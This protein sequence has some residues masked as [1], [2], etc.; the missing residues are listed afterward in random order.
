MILDVARHKFYEG[1]LTLAI[2]TLVMI[3]VMVFSLDNSEIAPA[4][5][6]MS[7]V[8]TTIKGGYFIERAAAIVMYV[9]SVLTLARSAIRTHIY[10]TNTMAPLAL[11][12]M[13]MFP[14]ICTGNTLHQSTITLLTAIALGNMFYCFGPHRYTNRLFI[15]MVAASALLVVDASFIAIPVA[16][17]IALILA[18]KRFREAIVAIT[19]MVLPIFT[20]CY[21]LW[22]VGREPSTIATQLWRDIT[23]PWSFDIIANFGY[24]VEHITLPRLIFVALLIIMQGVSSILYLTQRDIHSSVM[25]GVWRALHLIWVVALCSAFML[26]T[27]TWMLLTIALIAT[28]TML[29]MLFVRSNV[30]LSTLAYIALIGCAVAPII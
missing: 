21:V 7:L 2:M 13:I 14:L 19:G 20:Q 29:P 25:R 17:C 10:P 22:L 18:R 26:P 28:S 12:T 23:A 27:S 15:S 16:L 24:I 11:C 4:S 8:T 6:F 3:A 30:V 9:V 1:F 5:P